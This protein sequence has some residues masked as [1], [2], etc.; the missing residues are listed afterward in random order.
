MSKG[1][2][3]QGCLCGDKHGE[4]G[5]KKVLIFGAAGY[6][7][8]SLIDQLLEQNYQVLAVDNN[9]KNTTDTLISY[10]TNPN[11]EFMWG[12]ITDPDDVKK[13]YNKNIDYI[14]LAAAIVGAP[15]CKKQ[16]YLASLVNIGG[17][18]NVV[19]YKPQNVKLIYCNTGSIYKGGLGACNEQSII[20]PQSHYAR[21]KWEGEKIVLSINETI[22]Q[23]YATACGPSKTNMRVNLLCNDMLYQAITNKTLV[24]FEADFMRTFIACDDIGSS[25]VFTIEHFKEMYDKQKVYNVGHQDLNFTKRQLVELIQSYTKCHIFYADTEKDPDQRDYGYDS[26]AIYSFGWRPQITIEKTIEDLIKVTPL[27]NGWNKYN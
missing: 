12:D 26:S 22:S 17:T 15:A 1:K 10:I 27:L 4:V 24:I 19:K 3:Q 8:S 2:T 9:H 23:R 25:I 14:V 11:F 6:L 21:T 16:K 7:S 18:E 5:M 13:A 20:E